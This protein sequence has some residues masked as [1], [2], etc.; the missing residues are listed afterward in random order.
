MLILLINNL[1]LEKKLPE[2]FA[3]LKKMKYKAKKKNINN[4]LPILVGSDNYDP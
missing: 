1:I 2:H 3:N 4:D